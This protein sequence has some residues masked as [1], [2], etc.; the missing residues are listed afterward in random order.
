MTSKITRTKTL[1]SQVY[2][3]LLQKILNGHFLPGQRLI[4]EKLVEET[5]VSRSPI[6]E[7][8]R[9]LEKDG[10]VTV[11]PQ[12]GVSVYKITPSD[13]QYLYECRLSIEPTAARYAAERIQVDH[14]VQLEKVIEEMEKASQLNDLVKIRE[15][16][17]L[18]HSLIM[19]A[20]E[21]PF[22]IKMMKQLKVLINV[23][24][25]VLLQI[26]MRWEAGVK[27]HRAIWEAIRNRNGPAAEQWMIQHIQSDYQICMKAVKDNEQEEAL[28]GN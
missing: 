12:G 23:Y 26:S 21:N 24:R 8:I 9:R 25:N 28:T 13:F 18:F 17:A 1:Q 14:L 4:E 11:N 20:S 22:L 7:A 10:L 27:E 3:F 2:E 6:R 19:E 15:L 16:N 5:G